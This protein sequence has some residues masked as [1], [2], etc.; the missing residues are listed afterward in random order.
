[1][2]WVIYCPGVAYTVLVLK[3]AVI[4]AVLTRKNNLINFYACIPS[5]LITGLPKWSNKGNKCKSNFKKF[6]SLRLKKIF[7]ASISSVDRAGV[8]RPCPCRGGFRVESQR[9]A[10]CRFWPTFTFNFGKSFGT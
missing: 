5:G 10:L 7:G 6:K 9:G 2:S 1:M 8:E 4:C 3:A